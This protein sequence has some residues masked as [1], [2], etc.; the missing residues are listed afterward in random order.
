MKNSKLKSSY[1]EKMVVE[2]Q[3]LN[4]YLG[5]LSLNIKAMTRNKVVICNHPDLMR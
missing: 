2:L 4:Q 1:I 5:I 3:M